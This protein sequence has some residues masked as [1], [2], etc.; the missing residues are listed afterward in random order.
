MTMDDRNNAVLVLVYRLVAY[1]VIQVL[2]RLPQIV[3]LMEF[4]ASPLQYD[5]V[6]NPST[7]QTVLFFLHIICAPSAGAGYL[8]M[9][10]AAQPTIKN[11][12]LSFM[13]RCSSRLSKIVPVVSIQS[14][15]APDFHLESSVGPSRKSSAVALQYD[16]LCDDELIDAIN[17][18]M[19]LPMKAYGNNLDGTDQAQ[20]ESENK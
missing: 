3:Y 8:I 15:H 4:G 18:G 10:I 6:G 13:C 2:S 17:I 9:Y 5:D 12:L 19:M 11:A 1:P 16:L 20:L 14:S 7:F